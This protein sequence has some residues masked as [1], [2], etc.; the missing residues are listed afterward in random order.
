MKDT[1]CGSQLSHPL[2]LTPLKSTSSCPLP[3]LPPHPH[4]QQALE[5]SGLGQGALIF[6]VQ[7]WKP[8]PATRTAAAPWES[9]DGGE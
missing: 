4:P 2:C 5:A 9:G 1:S 8:R 3:S 7:F 6:S